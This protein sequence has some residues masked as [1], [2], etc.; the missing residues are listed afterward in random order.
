MK[1]LLDEEHSDPLRELL[2]ARAGA[3]WSSRLLELEAH[4][5]S[6][7]LQLDPDEVR[8]ALM[9]VSLVT[10]RPSTLEAALTAGQDNLRSLDAIHLAAALELGDEMEAM[11][12]YDRRLASSCES[13]DLPVLSPGLPN[14]WWTS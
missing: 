4:R 13:E 14:E 6:R 5:V 10:L 7:Q 8:E 1:V 2:A 3:L 12:V 9:A 11:V